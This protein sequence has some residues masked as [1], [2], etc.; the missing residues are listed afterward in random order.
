VYKEKIAGISGEDL[1]FNVRVVGGGAKSDVWNQIKA[2]I[3]ANS[4]SPIDREDVSTLGQALVAAAAAGY[5][6]DLAR[7][8]REVIKIRKT[9]YPDAAAGAVYRSSVARYKKMLGETN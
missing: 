4:Y 6:K 2:D 3:L 9:F 1:P 8:S 5:V 7:K